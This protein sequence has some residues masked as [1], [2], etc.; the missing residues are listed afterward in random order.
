MLKI[1]SDLLNATDQGKVSILTLLDLSAAFDTIDHE[2]MLNRLSTT[3]GIQGT[4]L[5][6]FRSYLVGR[7]FS[8]LIND[9]KSSNNVL[10]FGVPQGSVLGPVLYIMYTYPIGQIIRKYEDLSFHMYADD[11]Q[12]YGSVF[13]ENMPGLLDSMQ[14]CVSELNIWMRSNKLKM[15]NDK[16]EVLPIS[17]IHKLPSFDNNTLHVDGEI[18][19]FSKKVKNLGV[20]IDSSLSMNA[21]VNNICKTAYFQIR[22][23]GQ[24]RSPR[25]NVVLQTHTENQM[26]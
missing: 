7:S 15:N 20:Y 13:L 5:N 21:Q 22:K 19:P 4:V 1:I 12:L 23:I 25:R 10:D 2:I 11:T 24:L 16:T 6:W 18:V 8:V 3:F 26:D 17:T 9:L 14:S